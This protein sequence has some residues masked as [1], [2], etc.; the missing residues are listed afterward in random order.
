MMYIWAQGSPTSVKLMKSEIGR[1]KWIKWVWI[2]VFFIGSNINLYAQSQGDSLRIIVSQ[3][4]PSIK[5]SAELYSATPQWGYYTFNPSVQLSFGAP[6]WSLYGSY[7][8]LRERA[9]Q[10]SQSLYRYLDPEL[11]HTTQSVHTTHLGRHTYRVGAVSTLYPKHTF[12]FELYGSQDVPQKGLIESRLDLKASDETTRS[13]TSQQYHDRGANVHHLTGYYRWDFD[14]R[15]SYLQGVLTLADKRSYFRNGLTSELLLPL[16]LT[17]AEE[18]HHSLTHGRNFTASLEGC[19]HW[20]R[21]WQTTFGGDYSASRHTSRYLLQRGASDAPLPIAEWQLREKIGELYWGVQKTW[22]DAIR[23]EFT[24]RG[25]VTHID[26]RVP[27]EEPAAQQVVQTYFD[28]LPR[29]ALS[30]RLSEKFVYALS[31]ERSLFR[32][33]FALMNNF[34]V[35]QSELLYE[36]GNPWLKAEV[37][38]IATLSVQYGGHASSLKYRHTPRSIAEFFDVRHYAL[39]R[40]HFNY[41]STHSLTLD[42]SYSGAPFSWWQTNLYLAGMYT[43]IP[44][45]HYRKELFTAITSWNNL[46]TWRPL[47]AFAVDVDFETPRIYGHAFQEGGFETN[48]SYSRSL[49]DNRL[50]LQVG[51][52]DLFNTSDTSITH[53]LPHLEYLFESKTQSRAVWCKLSYHFGKATESPE[54]LIDEENPLERRL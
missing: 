22:G 13:G 46:F 48:L 8:Y 4:P 38:D 30:H 14:I 34:A 15:K 52:T 12:G 50:S 39:Y 7:S 53:R 51:I 28:G 41:G 43:R 44:W 2:A 5:G 32:M 29:F 36:E 23:A 37:I 21:A 9:Q 25:S 10:E 54:P 31:Y 42:Y 24:F 18:V 45:S 17:R 35:R 40:T 6:H 47:G 33:P 26:G 49:W 19:K 1:M 20:E 11:E 3:E 27:A 16:P